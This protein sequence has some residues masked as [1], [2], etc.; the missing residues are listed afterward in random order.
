MLNLLLLNGGL[1]K[2]RYEVCF[3]QS[4]KSPRSFEITFTKVTYFQQYG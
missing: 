4:M 2:V 1:R 3:I